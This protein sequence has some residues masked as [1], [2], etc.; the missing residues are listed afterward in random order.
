MVIDSP[1]P[2]HL[3]HSHFQ[4]ELEL[5]C[6][7]HILT[8]PIKRKQRSKLVFKIQKDHSDIGNNYRQVDFSTEQGWVMD[9]TKKSWE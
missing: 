9:S 6:Q 1:L 4:Q 7:G 3:L 8:I 2:S 5:C